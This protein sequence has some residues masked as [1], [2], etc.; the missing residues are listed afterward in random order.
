[1][2]SDIRFVSLG[3]GHVAQCNMIWGAARKGTA[4]S[5]RLMNKAK[6]EGK[7][8]DWTATRA[9]KSLIFLTNGYV[10]GSPFN[11]STVYARLRKATESDFQVV[12]PEVREGDPEKD[13][14]K[15]FMLM[16]ELL[17]E[18]D[19]EDEPDEE[20]DEEDFDD[21]STDENYDADNRIT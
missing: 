9:L 5:Q 4:Q 6:K 1:M 13:T 12:V 14:A 10:I 19:D 3:F 20:F 16:T 8:L 15:S 18:Q 11:V 21:A 7:Y 17:S 2:T